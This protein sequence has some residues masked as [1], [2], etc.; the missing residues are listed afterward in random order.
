[1][2]LKWKIIKILDIYNEPTLSAFDWTRSVGARDSFKLPPLVSWRDRIGVNL[3]WTPI[4]PQLDLQI[5]LDATRATTKEFV[6][7]GSRIFAPA[8]A[9]RLSPAQQRCEQS[10]SDLSHSRSC[11]WYIQQWW[12]QVPRQCQSLLRLQ[13]E[14]C[15]ALW[16]SKMMPSRRY[17]VHS[18]MPTREWS[19]HFTRGTSAHHQF[20]HG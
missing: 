13:L 11:S 10:S 16:S 12:Q 15:P 19:K 9:Q 14:R 18:L 5:Q 20:V 1:M 7:V 3:K 6:N 17:D 8:K 2:M 4:S